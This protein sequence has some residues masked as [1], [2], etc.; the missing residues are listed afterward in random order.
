MTASNEHTCTGDA[1]HVCSAEVNYGG[2]DVDW[3]NDEE[4][5]K[6]LTPHEIISL[7][8]QVTLSL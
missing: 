6:I 3:G 8:A 5:L 2:I 1:F 7:A 4:R